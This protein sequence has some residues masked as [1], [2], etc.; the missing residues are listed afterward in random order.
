M[1]TIKIGSSTMQLDVAQRYLNNILSR[2][3]SASVVI[4]GVSM[5]VSKAI[6]NVSSTLNTPTSQS[7][8]T[9]TKTTQA[10]GTSFSSNQSSGLT[11]NQLVDKV[12]LE[13][14]DVN[15]VQ[16]ESWWSSADLTERQKANDRIKQILGSPEELAKYAKAKDIQN[17][18]NY[19]W[20]A[21]NP[22]K[23][24]AWNI[25][26]SG[27]NNNTSINNPTSLPTAPIS[28]S[29]GMWEDAKTSV[30]NQI[31]PVTQQNATQTQPVANN[32][33]AALDSI[34]N[35]SRIPEALKPLFNRVV[36]N[37]DPTQELNIENVIASFDKIKTS[38]IDP[39]FKEQIQQFTN[40]LNTTLEYQ[41]KQI[42]AESEQTGT[43]A[44]ENIK[45]M[46][47]ALEGSGRTFTGE[48]INQLGAKSAYAQTGESAIPLQTPFANGQYSEGLVNQSNK[49]MSSSTAL[50]QEQQLKDLARQA[51]KTLGS[52]GM[53][54]TGLKAI[55]DVTQGTIEAEKQKAYTSTL[56]SLYNQQQNLNQYSEPVKIFS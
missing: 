28:T 3:P 26:Q 54:S 4:N 52:S 8:G 19:S 10:Q 22:N 45:G 40:D 38:T 20:W 18:Q 49:L 27:A 29:N 32:I 34:A 16:N 13:R 33:Q 51:E 17:I 37:W 21:T 55:G 12:L 7:V 14:K 36:E 46:Q 15:N 23:Q 43:V 11:A 2:N 42:A 25:I 35:D 39:Y 24:E 53:A 1:A 6:A 9:S 56:D 41:K 31:V 5:P 50:R 30:N 47:A 48:G 44:D